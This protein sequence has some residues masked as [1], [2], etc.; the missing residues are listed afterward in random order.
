MKKACQKKTKIKKSLIIAIIFGLL[1]LMVGLRRTSAQTNQRTFT[2]SPPTINFNLEPGKSEEK[3]IKITNNSAEPMTFV[4]GIQDFIVNDNSGTPE[5]LPSGFKPDNKYAAST[6]ATAYPELVTVQPGKTATTT[7]YLRVP[8]NARPGGKYIS[9]TLRPLSSDSPDG[10]GAAVSTVIG[11][12]A[13]IT[14][15]GDVEEKA[16]IISFTAPTLSEYGPI[17]FNTEIKNLGDLHINPKA[18]VEVKNLF[19]KKVHSFALDNLNIF[20]GTSRI[21]ENNWETKWL[22]GRYTANLSGYYGQN[23]QLNLV[24]LASFWVIPYKLIAIVLLAT[25]LV[26]ITAFYLKKRNEPQEIEE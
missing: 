10:S 19:G 9:L 13:Y 5:L 8:G 16:Q 22:F 23:N 15:A 3:T 12:L 2:I 6:W 4:I 20:P 18:T 17:P 25:A 11:T 1:S 24:A 14:V 21:Y 7:L 26:L